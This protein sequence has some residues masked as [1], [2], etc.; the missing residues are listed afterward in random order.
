MVVSIR[1][2]LAIVHYGQS[3]GV[4]PPAVCDG[5]VVGV[6]DVFAQKLTMSTDAHGFLIIIKCI[7]CRFSGCWGG[8][9]V[10]EGPWSGVPGL[11]VC[12]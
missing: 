8:W 2:H 3:T 9:A 11:V 1:I 5:C 12:W 7:I 4:M 6:A 10:P